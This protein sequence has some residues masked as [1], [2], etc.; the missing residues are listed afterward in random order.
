MVQSK[1]ISIQSKRQ[2]ISSRKALRLC[3]DGLDHLI[4]SYTIKSMVPAHTDMKKGTEKTLGKH[5][6]KIQKLVFHGTDPQ[7]DT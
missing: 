1:F 6:Q 5:L 4:P 7:L 3:Q 2:I